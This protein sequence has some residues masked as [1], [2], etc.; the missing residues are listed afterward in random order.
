MKNK[1]AQVLCDQIRSLGIAS[2][3]CYFSFVLAGI[4]VVM[5]QKHLPAT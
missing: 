4:V 3:T 5:F 2:Y 1:E